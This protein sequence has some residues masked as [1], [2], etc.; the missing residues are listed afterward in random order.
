MISP[1][2]RNFAPTVAIRPAGRN[3][4]HIRIGLVDMEVLGEHAILGIG[5]FPTSQRRTRLGG[6][7]GLRGRVTPIRS[8]GTNQDAITWLEELDVATHF[9]DD[10]HRLV[11]QGQV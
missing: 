6:V 9:V 3:T 2:P 5:E 10:A 1:A 11:S 7:T 8:D 4:G